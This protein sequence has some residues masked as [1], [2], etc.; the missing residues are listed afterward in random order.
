MKSILMISLHGYVAASPELGKPDT[1]GQVVY[2]LELAERFS[3]LGRRVDLL[4]RQF[5]DQ[6]EYDHVNENYNIWRIP[7]GGK[8]F[9]RKEDMHDYLKKF[10][11]NTLAAI[12]K[13]NKKYDIVYSHYWDAGWAGQKI[14]EELGISHVHTP[15]SLGWWK[16]H[17]MGSDMD[18]KEMEKTYRF[19]ERIQKEYFVFQM[20]NHVI[21]T[22]IPQVDLL[23]QQYDLLPRNCTM[24]PPGID[25]NR[26]Y[27]VPSKENDKIRAK[28]DIHPTDILALGRM[29]HNKGYDLLIKALPTVFELVPEARLVAAVG[30]D[31]AQDKQGIKKLKTLANKL[32]VNDKIKWKNYI[33]DEDLAN[34]YRSANIFAMPSR[35]EPFGMVA[36]EA[37]ACGTPSVITV[38]GGLNDL[39]DFGNQAL[40]ADP[41]RPIEFGA[42]MSMPLL[43]PN[44]RNELSVEGA[45]FARRNFG[46]TGI[47]KRM[48]KVFTN[49]INQR[50][51]ESNIF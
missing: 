24:I 26:F 4:T 18:E 10:V 48:L 35:Y 31:S 47:A 50:T 7:F 37:M 43:Y 17:T 5:E 3:R 11:T 27:P 21:A 41:H 42:M 28:Y 34:V 19:K 13:E 23:T 15:H 38:H 39:I 22:T 49:S 36:I 14:A 25:E 20:C 40:F 16:Q 8:E 29:A 9:I 12:K 45:R 51:M 2:V 6:P 32:G 33:A 1:G 30:G 44:L 46:W